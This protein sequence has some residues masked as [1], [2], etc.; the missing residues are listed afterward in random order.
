MD[1]ASLRG[2]ARRRGYPSF[3][4]AA[5]LARI[6]D[7]M[8]SVGVVLLV[9]DRTQDAA[10]AGATIAAVTLP[11]LVTGPLL[12]ARMDITGRRRT[13]MIID[14]ALMIATL[15]AILALTGNAPEWLIPLAALAGGLTWPLS[16]G[17]FSSLVGRLAGPQLVAQ[18][19]ALEASSI[20][21]ALV[22]GPALAGTLSATIGPTAPLVTE[23]VLT[24]LAVALIMRVPGLDTPR[25]PDGRSL[26]GVAWEG[27]VLIV[28][29]PPLRAV[30][31]AGSLGLA[32]LGMLVI[33]AP[34]FAVENL[35]VERSAAG[36]LWAAFAVGSMTG[37]LTLVRLQGR[38]EPERLML[39]SLAGF[40]ALMLLQPLQ[41]DFVLMLIVVAAGGFVE[42]PG[43][44][45]TFA[46]RQRHVPEALHGQVFTTAVGFKV[47]S[48]ALGSAIGGPLVVGLG[49]EGVYWVAAGMQFAAVAVGGALLL[50]RDRR[51]GAPARE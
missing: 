39:C 17:G 37:A 5:T 11:S 15:V 21:T 23:I 20:N 49:A 18:A 2:L 32:G 44:A 19:N 48:L 9:L 33:A 38:F 13:L 25:E 14:G 27:V 24:A 12:G 3:L 36:Y 28:R 41:T 26:V 46:T 1:R 50:T 29:S 40:G 6:A 42:G 45:A 8:F 47:G 51:I 16:F 10:I 31:A 22:V 4:A 7:E 35:G 34:F 30:T 43:L